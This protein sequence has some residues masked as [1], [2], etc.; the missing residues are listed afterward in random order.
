VLVAAAAV[1]A[2]RRTLASRMLVHQQLEAWHQGAVLDIACCPRA[3]FLASGSVDNT[4]CVWRLKRLYSR[5]DDG[6]QRVLLGKNAKLWSGRHGSYVQALL[7]ARAHTHTCTL[8]TKH[9][10]TCTH[11]HTH[12]HTCT[13]MHTHAHSVFV[14]VC[15]C[16]C[17]D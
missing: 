11:M 6:L 4:V 5:S 7:Q 14:C 9:T 8:N 17:V 3:E 2:A 13:H 10:H 1:I 16:V 15:V 12:A